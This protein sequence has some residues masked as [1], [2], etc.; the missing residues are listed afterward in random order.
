MLIIQVNYGS[1][2]G[3]LFMFVINCIS[4]NLSFYKHEQISLKHVKEKFILF[5]DMPEIITFPEFMNNGNNKT[6]IEDFFYCP[7]NPLVNCNEI[8]NKYIKPH[9]DY[10]L[11]FH[12][13]FIN[14]DRDLIIHIRS[15][16]VFNENFIQNREMFE[17]FKSPP[18]QFYKEIIE[19]NHFQHIYIISENYNLNPVIK[20][21][22]K[23]Y[24]N[25]FSFSND[26]ST[27]FRIL[28]NAK[29]FIPGHSDLSRMVLLLSKPKIKCYIS[30]PIFPNVENICY[31]DY[32]KYYNTFVN[33]YGEYIN[34]IMNWKN[35]HKVEY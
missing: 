32:S 30:K 5:K 21:L 31:Y 15:G 6:M 14:F 27:D 24:Q 17:A 8:V 26:L 1:R 34:L 11:N 2:T 22:C 33:S 16:D 12:N 35:S 29:Y 23:N 18:Y 20:E 28:L 4:D 10:N 3:N 25:I 13:D 19:S 7:I 9:I